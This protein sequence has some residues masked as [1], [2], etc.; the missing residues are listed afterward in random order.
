MPTL[1]DVGTLGSKIWS[2][3]TVLMSLYDSPLLMRMAFEPVHKMYD[4]TQIL[5][6]AAVG[7]LKHSTKL[8]TLWWIKAISLQVL[9]GDASGPLGQDEEAEPLNDTLAALELLRSQFPVAA[10][11]WVLHSALSC[12][13]ESILAHLHSWKYGKCRSSC[14]GKETH[15]ENEEQRWT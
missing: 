1:G 6:S 4:W 7:K 3:Q 11:V 14:E 15:L 5:R 13:F 9:G 10:Q 8:Q 2:C 12:I